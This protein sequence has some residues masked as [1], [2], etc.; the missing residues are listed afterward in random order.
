MFGDVDRQVWLALEEVNQ[1]QLLL[2]SE[3]FSDDIYIYIY[4]GSRGPTDSH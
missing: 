3:G 1:I 2:D 4:A